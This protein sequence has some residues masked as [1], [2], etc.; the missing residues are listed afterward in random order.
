[1]IVSEYKEEPAI[2]RIRAEIIVARDS[3]KGILIGHQGK[4][5][6]RVGTEARRDIESF[7]DKK[8]FLEIFVKVDQ[9]WRN[10]ESKLKRFG[11]LD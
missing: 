2:V 1:V 3:Q 10:D 8:V 6:K 7:I 4:M 5:L 11:Y 9:N